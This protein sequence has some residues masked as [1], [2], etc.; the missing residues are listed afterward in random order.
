MGFL[1]MFLNGLSHLRLNETITLTAIW[2]QTLV[3]KQRG[4]RMNRKLENYDDSDECQILTQPTVSVLIYGLCHVICIYAVAS[5][6]SY[7]QRQCWVKSTTFRY[8]VLS[9]TQHAIVWWANEER[10]IL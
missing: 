4:Y 10:D 8:L 6:I 1:I 9:F 3:S 2:W 7:V 5:V